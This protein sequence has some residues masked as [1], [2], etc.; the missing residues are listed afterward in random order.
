[1]FCVPR[2]SFFFL[3]SPCVS[4]VDCGQR[5]AQGLMSFART[6]WLHSESASRINMSVCI[7]AKTYAQIAWPLMFKPCSRLHRSYCNAMFD[8]IPHPPPPSSGKGIRRHL[9]NV[10]RALDL[11]LSWVLVSLIQVW[12]GIGRAMKGEIG[13]MSY[14]GPV[15]LAN[16]CP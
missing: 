14:T 6:R 5:D 7:N 15:L 3:S 8:P 11:F 16:G 2:L 4:V 12:G 13:I 10:E 9:N 1:M